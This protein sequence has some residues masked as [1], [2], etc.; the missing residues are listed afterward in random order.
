[1]P[2]TLMS[3]TEVTE[4]LRESTRRSV[5]LMDI[6][7]VRKFAAMDTFPA[8]IAG[9]LAVFIAIAAKERLNETK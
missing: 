7:T 3:P 1:M 6:T 2:N 5:A 8:G 4:M 9:G